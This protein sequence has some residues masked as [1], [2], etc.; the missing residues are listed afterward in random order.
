MELNNVLLYNTDRISG[1][2]RF[3]SYCK[4]INSCRNS[5][6]IADFDIAQQPT[7]MI[8]ECCEIISTTS[9]LF[10]KTGSPQCL[11]HCRPLV[12][13]Q[14]SRIN[15]TPHG[16]SAQPATSQN[17]KLGMTPSKRDLSRVAIDH[18]DMGKS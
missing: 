13:L 7:G 3:A 10:Y 8:S 2:D 14:F 1:T 15:L 16:F 5:F 4:I 18:A 9:Q 6:L 12:I 17:K 11:D